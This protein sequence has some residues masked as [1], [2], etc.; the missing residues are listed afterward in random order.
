MNNPDIKGK[1]ILFGAGNIGRSFLGQLFSR[2]G[3]EVVFVDINAMI[4]S[5]LNQKHQYRVIIKQND[6]PDET[7][8]VK[9][10]RGIHAN[11][12]QKLAEEIADA[13]IMATAVGKSALPYILP[14]IAQGLQRRLQK[15]GK[16]P[17]DII[18]AENVRNVSGY[19]YAEL[20]KRLPADYKLDELVGLVE[21]SIGKMVPIMKDEDV[22][23]D[24]LWIFAEPYNTLIVDKCGFKN[25]I[26]A[27]DGISAKDNIT[28][29]VDRKLFIHNLGHAA[30]AYFGYQH[31]PAFLY[32]YEPLELPEIFQKVKQ[33]MM[34][35]A[36]ALNREYPADLS[37][38][39]LE[40]HIYDLLE[41]FQNKALGDTIFRVG[42]DLYRKLDKNDRLVG[43][44]LLAKRHSGRCDLIAEAVIA[45]CRFRARDEHGQLFPEDQEFVEKD[46]PQGIE[47]ILT[48][49]CHLSREHEC[50][51]EVIDEILR[52]S[53][54]NS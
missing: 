4:I 54:P 30:A 38:P 26:P 27:I 46:F 22:R 51:S 12:T 25:P 15:I 37:M 52:G 10:V 28:A 20:K 19:V 47:H 2:G 3:Y 44:M 40:D 53:Q 8:W 48:H 34:Q 1:L 13:S 14:S 35:S 41:R 6:R 42:R 49:I 31:N 45:A 17:L 9:N 39:D 50:E 23:K 18:M 16:A 7:I 43:A 33:C 32:I 5:E 11:D 29:F 36:V 21:T 24:S